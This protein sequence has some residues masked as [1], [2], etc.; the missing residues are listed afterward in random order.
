MH[1]G[2]KEDFLFVVLL[3][4]RIKQDNGLES[5]RI[6][7]PSTE[8]PTS[9]YP[10]I[11]KSILKTPILGNKSRTHALFTELSEDKLEGQE[12]WSHFDRVTVPTPLG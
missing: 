9:Y 3:K 2:N 12:E 11:R 8:S 1:L 6:F 5:L 10:Q 7:S 4:L